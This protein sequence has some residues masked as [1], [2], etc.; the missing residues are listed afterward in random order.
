MDQSFHSTEDLRALGFQV[1]GGVSMLAAAVPFSRRLIGVTAFMMALAVPAVVY[2]GLMIRLAQ[3]GGYDLA[4]ADR[5]G[6]LSVV[7]KARW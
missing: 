2:G 7:A 3:A 5:V 1:A 4:S 6:T